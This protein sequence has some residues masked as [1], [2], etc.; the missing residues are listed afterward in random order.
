MINRLD[1]NL[2]GNEPKLYSIYSSPLSRTWK[3]WVAVWWRWVLIEPYFN[4]PLTDLKGKSCCTNQ[5]LPNVWFLAGTLG[6]RVKRTCTI[7]PD[8]SILFPIVNNLITYGEYPKLKTCDQL[9]EYAS[10]DIDL[11]SVLKCS[12]DSHEIH[13]LKAYRIQSQLFRVSVKPNSICGKE[14]GTTYGISDGY[15][16]FI[17]PLSTGNHCIHFVGEKLKYD[18]IEFEDSKRKLPKFKVEVEYKIEVS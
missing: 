7:L 1:G 8:T 6:G 18:E 17:K 5:K 4:N 14:F 13:N 10:N 2:T 12:I 16:V 11:T 15:W 3:E 9:K